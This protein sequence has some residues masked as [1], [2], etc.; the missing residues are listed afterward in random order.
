ME[1]VVEAFNTAVDSENKMHDND[2]ARHFG[3]RGGLVPGVD[4]YAYLTH[5]PVHEWGSDW[6]EHGTMTARF[7]VP[8]YDGE[9][10]TVRSEPESP[11]N[12]LTIDA[13]N[14]AGDVCA[15]AT[16][17]LPHDA[18]PPPD[19]DEVPAAPLNAD[20]RPAASPESLAVGSLLGSVEV[21]FH[22]DKATPYLRDIRED[23]KIYEQEG[24]AHPGWLLR[25]ANKILAINVQLGP[26]I[27]VGSTVT[28]FSAV[29]DG[30]RVSTRARVTDEYE[31][32]GHRFVELD[33]LIV[34][35]GTTP[36]SRIHHVAIYEP[37]Q[38]NG[39]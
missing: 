29:H 18:P 34:A 8:V 26:W 19:P 31:R 17:E 16:A 9:K 21:G 5:A 30:Q 15:T 3:F 4:V 20:P 33:V 7:L 12:R 35:D 37:R 24:V 28:N 2:V 10:T 11:G 32:K 39:S 38:P 36:V 25:F 22:A 1:Y 6:L 27:H 14:P 23:L 13:I